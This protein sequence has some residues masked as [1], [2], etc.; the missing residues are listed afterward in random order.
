MSL[1]NLAF[2]EISEQHLLAQIEA[3]VPEGVLVDYKRDAYEVVKT[4]LD[5]TRAA[6]KSALG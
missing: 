1:S 3:G 5:K 4:G 2:D 6:V